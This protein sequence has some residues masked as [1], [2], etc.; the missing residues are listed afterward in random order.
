MCCR[1]PECLE[2]DWGSQ[3][4]EFMDIQLASHDL[5]IVPSYLS[6]TYQTYKDTEGTHTISNIHDCWKLH[7]HFVSFHVRTLSAAVCFWSCRLLT[8]QIQTYVAWKKRCIL[9]KL[10]SSSPCSPKSKAFLTKTH[11]TPHSCVFLAYTSK[12]GRTFHRGFQRIESIFQ[13]GCKFLELDTLS[14]LASESGWSVQTS[15]CHDEEV[16]TTWRAILR[17]STQYFTDQEV[18]TIRT[19]TPTLLVIQGPEH[20]QR[21]RTEQHQGHLFPDHFHARNEVKAAATGRRN[22]YCILQAI[23]CK[24]W[25]SWPRSTTYCTCCAG[26]FVLTE[27]FEGV[28]FRFH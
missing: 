26:K 16:S 13:N 24:K 28:S 4:E 22:S 17:R 8:S 25:S 6:S 3:C 1:I 11:C 2:V 27:H 10:H 7:L 5:D 19:L 21:R 20:I 23:L 14:P 15:R 12:G 9:R 18:S